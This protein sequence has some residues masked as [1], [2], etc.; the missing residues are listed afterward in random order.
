MLKHG[1]CRGT[2]ARSID[3]GQ[4]ALSICAAVVSCKAAAVFVA[5]MRHILQKFRHRSPDQPQVV[6]QLVTY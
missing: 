6:E 4:K 1:R 5:Y 2:L 3:V